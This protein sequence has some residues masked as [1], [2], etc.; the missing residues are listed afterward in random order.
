[1]QSKVN[2]ILSVLVLVFFIPATLGFALINHHC[3]GCQSHDKE[4]VFLLTAHTH[5]DASCFCTETATEEASHDCEQQEG[6]CHGDHSP[7]K[8]SHDCVVELKKLEEPFTAASFDNWLPI[9]LEIS[10]AA[11]FFADNQS[12]AESYSAN[13]APLLFSPPIQLTGYE[14]LI[15]NGVFRL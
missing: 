4:T 9:P 13:T 12:S 1:M 6:S 14:R 2:V 11:L 3:T 8:H 15:K 5:D 10:V 7:E